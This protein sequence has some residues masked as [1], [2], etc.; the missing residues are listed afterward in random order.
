MVK[1]F[2]LE[3]RVQGEG[4]EGMKL[5]LAAYIIQVLLTRWISSRGPLPV[6]GGEG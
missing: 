6:A 5:S 3:F 1:G 4:G 2:R